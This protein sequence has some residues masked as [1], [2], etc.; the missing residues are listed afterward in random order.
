[1]KRS[2]MLGILT[3][4]SPNPSGQVRGTLN[5]GRRPDFELRSGSHGFTLVEMITVLVV[6]AILT[7]ISVPMGLT[8]LGTHRFSAMV[9]A[10]PNA[11]LT[12]RMRGIENRQVIAIK[13]SSGY[14]SMPFSSC[15][16][17]IQ[18]V[19]TSDHGLSEPSPALANNL[20]CTTTVGCPG[21][22]CGPLTNSFCRKN[23]VS[24]TTTPGDMVMITGLDMHKSMNG[25]EFEVLKVPDSTHFVVQHAFTGA[26]GDIASGDTTGTVRQL[27]APGR[28]RI[29][30]AASVTTATTNDNEE[31]FRSSDFTVKEEGSSIVF[32]YD[33]D[34]FLAYA[35][36]LNPRLVNGAPVT[37]NDS[38]SLLD[39]SSSNKS[40]QITFDTRGFPLG[41]PTPQV[42]WLVEKVS[43]GLNKGA[44]QVLYKI[45]ATGKVDTRASY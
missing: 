45:S 37:D 8:W 2:R 18:F 11:V 7:A 20:V 43:S 10:F 29:V 12:A 40:A 1:M 4:P 38:A 26:L 30:P 33:T 34:K 19:T 39:P 22:Y 5:C 42:L 9:R 15:C 6:I 13:D 35:N 16:P 28:I 25:V 24:S 14:S 32:R 17:G 21:T 36:P 31:N 41:L 27:T 3:P 44:R 23:L